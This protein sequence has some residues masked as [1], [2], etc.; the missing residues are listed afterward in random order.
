M[1]F[2]LAQPSPLRSMHMYVDGMRACVCLCMTLRMHM[3]VQACLA[4]R[5]WEKQAGV[6]RGMDNS[7]VSPFLVY[8]L[9]PGYHLLHNGPFDSFDI[10]IQIWKNRIS[11]SILTLP[12]FDHAHHPP[13]PLLYIAQCLQ[14]SRGR[15]QFELDRQFTLPRIVTRRGCNHSHVDEG[16]LCIFRKGSAHLGGK[17][18]VHVD[19]LHYQIA[20]VE[21]EGF[22]ICSLRHRKLSNRRRLPPLL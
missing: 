21:K 10:R 3:C 6:G 2:A 22:R 17:R 20:I 4:W 16:L 7:R 9:I 14:R 5:G 13:P 8:S 15:I 1:Y 12:L 11:T 18:G 19:N